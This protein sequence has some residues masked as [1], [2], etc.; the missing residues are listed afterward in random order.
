MINNRRTLSFLSIFIIFVKFIS[1]DILDFDAFNGSGKFINAKGGIITSPDGKPYDDVI[2]KLYVW[3]DFG[4]DNYSDSIQTHEIF[5]ALMFNGTVI[6]ESPIYNAEIGTVPSTNEFHFILARNKFN[7]GVIEN[8]ELGELLET[9]Y[10][11]EN[12]PLKNKFYN[13]IKIFDSKEKLNLA[14]D[15]TFGIN[16]YPLIAKQ[17]LETITDVNT[18]VMNSISTTDEYSLIGNIRMMGNYKFDNVKFKNVDNLNGYETESLIVS[19]GAETKIH[20]NLK[21]GTMH[22]FIDSTTDMD[23]YKGSRDDFY[24]QGGLYAVYDADS[25]IYSSLLSVGG[26][27][28]DIYRYNSSPLGDFI[29]KSNMTNLVLGLNNS[30]YKKFKFGK[31][32]ISP[33]MELNLIG[34]HQEEIEE[35]GDYGLEIDKINSLSIE[36]GIGFNIEKTF[37]IT[38]TTRLNIGAEVMSYIEIADPYKNLDARLK[39]ISPEKYTIEKYDNSIYHIDFSL[40]QGLKSLNGLGFYLTEDYTLSENQEQFKFGLNISYIF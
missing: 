35:D 28:T 36:P 8:N 23:N 3:G 20:S 26:S 18:S 11:N 13:D 22:S 19:V 14:I 37:D 2:G 27:D 30:I 7:G 32:Y 33:K 31:S 5:T 10:F 39:T 17:T 24:Y 1:A 16:F 21:I 9:G 38:Y 25:V 29:N 12:N 40:K 6:S 34:L 4:E 15:E